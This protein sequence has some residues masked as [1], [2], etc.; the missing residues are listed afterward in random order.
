MALEGPYMDDAYG[1][2]V[3]DTPD[4]QAQKVID[5]EKI[6]AEEAANPELAAFD[7]SARA[8]EEAARRQAGGN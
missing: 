4:N 7:A 2:A 6:A 1:R 8:A 3:P 5:A